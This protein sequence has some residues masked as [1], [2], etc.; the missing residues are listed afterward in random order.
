MLNDRN[1]DHLYCAN[2]D[3]LISA[4]REW[5]QFDYVSKRTFSSNILLLEFSSLS[6]SSFSILPTGKQTKCRW[7]AAW[8][9]ANGMARKLKVDQSISSTSHSRK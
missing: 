7:I 6:K 3:R 5:L 4:I 2:S 8:Q 9:E 1:P